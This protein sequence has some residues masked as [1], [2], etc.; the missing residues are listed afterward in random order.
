MVP[1]SGLLVAVVLPAIVLAGA[2]AQTPVPP[3][4]KAFNV[5]GLPAGRYMAIALDRLQAGEERDPE[6]LDRIRDSAARLTLV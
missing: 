5:G 3:V 6:L 4:A 1:K 2:S